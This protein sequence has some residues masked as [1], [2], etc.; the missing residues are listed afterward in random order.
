MQEGQ[1]KADQTLA[2]FENGYGVDPMKTE[3]NMSKKKDACK[4]IE[5]HL[6]NSWYDEPPFQLYSVPQYVPIIWAHLNS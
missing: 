1:H 4:L 2:I 5:L 6:T 3:K